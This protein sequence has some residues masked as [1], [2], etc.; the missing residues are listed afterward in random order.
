MQRRQSVTTIMTLASA[1]LI[2]M[3]IGCGSPS[4]KSPASLAPVDVGFNPITKVGPGMT[5]LEVLRE[6]PPPT[7]M[8][9]NT[10]YYK[11][12]G[13]VVFEG[14]TNPTDKTKVVKVEPDKMEDGLAP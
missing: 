2:G 10:Y 5:L 4:A 8:K 11:D 12:L 7:D 3:V 9:G 6:L 14:T 1:I 13:R